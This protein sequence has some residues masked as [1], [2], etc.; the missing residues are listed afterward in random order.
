MKYG[1]VRVAAAVPQV[2]VADCRYNASQAEE[3]I[4]EADENNVQAIVFRS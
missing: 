1:F 3:M 4:F 2:K